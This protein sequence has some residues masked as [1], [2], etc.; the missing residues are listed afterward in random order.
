MRSLESHGRWLRGGDRT[1][2]AMWIWRYGSRD[3]ASVPKEPSTNGRVARGDPRGAPGGCGDDQPRA[4]L[5][6]RP[7]VRRRLASPEMAGGDPRDDRGPGDPVPLR[8][9]DAHLR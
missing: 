8:P 5:D 6:R 1:T 7:G 9:T 2:Y 3:A 4:P